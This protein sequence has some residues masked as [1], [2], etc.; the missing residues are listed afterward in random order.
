VEESANPPVD[1]GT[2]AATLDVDVDG[3]VD[4]KGDEGTD[5]ATTPKES[6]SELPSQHT[7]KPAMDPQI[8]EIEKS[9]SEPLLVPAH[10]AAI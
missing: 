3:K 10:R 2:G 9:A 4:E 1:E 6:T 7:E 5:E 8:G